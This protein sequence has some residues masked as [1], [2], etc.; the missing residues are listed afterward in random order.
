[1]SGGGAVVHRVLRGLGC[2]LVGLIALAGSSCKTLEQVGIPPGV[3]T[4]ARWSGAAL[5]GEVGRDWWK[6]FGNSQL[7]KLIVEALDNNADL[8]A[9]A[10][11]VEAAAVQVR[12]AGA[13]LTPSVS[14]AVG[15]QRDKRNFVGFPIP[16][17]GGN[18]LTT[19]SSTH[20]LSLITNWEVDLWGRIR[21]G[22]RAAQQDFEASLTDLRGARLSLA[23]RVASGWIA[24]VEARQQLE[25]A[26]ET[27]ESH[28]ATEGQVRRRYEEG[29]RSSL[30]L[31]LAL[32]SV[33]SAESFL[34]E[35]KI[36]LE[37]ALRQLEILLGR[38]PKGALTSVDA[39]PDLPP[40]IPAGLPA[41]MLAR[42]PDVAAAGQRLFAADSRIKQARAA[43]LPRI[44][45]TA[46]G[47]ITT[48]DLSDLLSS[49]FTVWTLAGNLAQ[50]ILDG[51]RLRA[52][53]KL[54]NARSRLAAAQY[55]SIAYSAFRDVETA[56]VAEEILARREVRLQTASSHSRAAYELARRRYGEGL[57]SFATVLETQRRTLE[58]RSQLTA[59]R[60]QR[61]ENRVN[62]HLALGGGFSPPPVEP[63]ADE[64]ST[65][66]RKLYR[67]K[68]KAS[69]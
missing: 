29:L 28:R 47:G 66:M 43:L 40:A 21:A 36:V 56:L 9:A 24:V 31:R 18:V 58:S 27:I 45:L 5:E 38:Y 14:G 69:L 10:V 44:S 30:D 60:R 19:H 42:R 35:R 15:A 52:G 41:E 65:I 7:N 34:E 57:E 55:Q 62:L 50:P 49:D 46:Q 4:P 59:L 6:S 63:P 2:G 22:K 33:A 39:L 53:I 67:R 16:G 26:R 1:M 3:E 51:G 25:I 12:I 11:R 48:A 64:K 61:L 32:A 23:A 20:S 68:A 54:A 8:Q 37:A 17:G 13:D